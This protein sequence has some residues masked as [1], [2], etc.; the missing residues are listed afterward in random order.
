MT[1]NTFFTILIT[2]F[3]IQFS[4]A[5]VT[6]DS[7]KGGETFAPLSKITIKWTETQDHGE[8]DW[9]IYYSLD[10]GEVWKEIA[11]DI[12]D[13]SYEYTWEVPIAETSNAKIKI[14]QDNSSGT[15]FEDI[16]E[17]FTIS[18]TP[19]GDSEPDIVTALDDFTIHS[20]KDLQL[21]NYPNP[22]NTHTTIQFSI[23]Q[24]SHIILNVYN[25][26]GKLVYTGVDETYDKGTYKILWK[27]HGF[28]GGIYLCK[29]T[30][31][32]QKIINRMM[33]RP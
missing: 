3:T 23:S 15:A 10:G 2:V 22:F 14:V 27:S 1:H 9:D 12:E 18:N 24:K 8:N 13:A 16:S 21:S 6:L 11:I 17:K 33:L 30:A 26:L 7:P 32:D 28:P 5:H 25:T 19:G 20:N 4:H 31:D 29:L